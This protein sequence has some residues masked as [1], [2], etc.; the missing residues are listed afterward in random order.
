MKNHIHLNEESNYSQLENRSPVS[1]KL[2]NLSK[3]EE[4]ENKNTRFDDSSES[5]TNKG[6]ALREHQFEEE[7]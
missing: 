2:S 5:G 7:K 4:E 1:R 6:D 3:I